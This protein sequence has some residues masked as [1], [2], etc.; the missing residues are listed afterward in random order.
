MDNGHNRRMCDQ[1][2]QEAALGEVNGSVIPT[3]NDRQERLAHD[4]YAAIGRPPPIPSW[5][6]STIADH[7]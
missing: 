4:G 1:P 2:A 6:A 3:A 7:L 5:I